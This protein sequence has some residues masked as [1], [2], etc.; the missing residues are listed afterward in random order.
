M[1]V[2]DGFRAFI[3]EQLAGIRG[4]HDRVMFG[5][6]GL[7]DGDVFFGI[8]A[9]D[10]LYLKVDDSTRGRYEAAGMTPFKPYADRPMTI[11]GYYEVPVRVL[12][13]ADEL[14]RWARAATRVGSRAAALAHPKR[15]P[16]KRG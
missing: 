6:I 1:R 16:A 13:D 5:G 10:S 2:S 11:M 12:E 14:V 8:V 7:Y 3:L 4:L 9:R 15:T